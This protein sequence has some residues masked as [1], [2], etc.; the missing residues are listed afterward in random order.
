[1]A[2]ARRNLFSP[3]GSVL[4][5]PGPLLLTV[6][7]SLV[8]NKASGERPFGLISS[9]TLFIVFPAHDIFKNGTATG[10]SIENTG[11]FKELF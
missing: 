1:M 3:P 2:G 7:V 6:K 4:Q 10:L 9:L 11:P 5:V 8:W